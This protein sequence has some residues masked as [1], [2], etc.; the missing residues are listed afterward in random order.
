MFLE[1]NDFV[2]PSRYPLNTCRVAVCSYVFF[3]L[4][5]VCLYVSM[6]L[7]FLFRSNIFPSCF[8]FL[9]FWTWKQYVIMFLWLCMRSVCYHVCMIRYQYNSLFVYSSGLG[10]SMSLSLLNASA[11]DKPVEDPHSSEHLIALQQLQE[12]LD[13]SKKQLQLKDQQLLERDKKVKCNRYTLY[14]C[15]LL[16]TKKQQHCMCVCNGVC[17]FVDHRVESSA[18]WVGEGVSPEAADSTETAHRVTGRSPGQYM[19]T[20]AESKRKRGIGL[21]ITKNLTFQNQ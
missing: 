3:G 1:E 18:L 13:S 5:A 17:L 20:S 4:T 16:F 6:N 15:K 2:S 9:L 10:S 11:L 8:F 21:N 19:C 12:Q 14:E 7:H